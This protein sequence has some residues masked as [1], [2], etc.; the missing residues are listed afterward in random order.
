MSTSDCSHIVPRCLVSGRVS[1]ASLPWLVLYIQCAAM[2]ASATAC[3]AA[4]RIWN[5]IAVPSGL[6]TVVCS[7]W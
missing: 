6:T 1:G 2:P 5:S 7:D 3:I 4:V